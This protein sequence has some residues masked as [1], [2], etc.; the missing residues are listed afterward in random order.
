[1]LAAGILGMTSL[2][3]AADSVM[4]AAIS[5]RGGDSGKCTIE[6]EV[7]GAADVEI[8]EDI[9]RL[10]TL[11]GQPSTWRRF[12]CNQP[13]PLN[14]AEFRFRGIDGRGKVEL[15]RDPRSGR[16]VAVVRIQDPKGGR[17]GYTFD[18]E[19]KGAYPP[20]NRGSSGWRRRN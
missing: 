11:S 13:M 1:M 6:V 12:Q 10:H 2:A 7:D 4:R 8:R 15:I 17:E 18:L 16:G 14:P 3:S 19:W 9:G 20:G 5:G